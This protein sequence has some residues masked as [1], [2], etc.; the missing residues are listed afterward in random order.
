MEILIVLLPTGSMDGF[1]RL[2]KADTTGFRFLEPVFSV[3]VPG[4]INSLG[5]TMSGNH[6]VVGVGQE[7]KLGRWFRDKKGKNS[8]VV[9]PLKKN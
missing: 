9:I 6:L 7:H 4:V 1:V 3:P 2:W 5:F 8:I